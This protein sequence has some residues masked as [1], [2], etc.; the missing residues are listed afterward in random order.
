MVLVVVVFVVVFVVVVVV[1]SELE[2]AEFM[3]T[4]IAN[5]K[6]RKTKETFLHGIRFMVISTGQN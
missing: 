4:N 6:P 1:F 5:N 3:E 2:Q